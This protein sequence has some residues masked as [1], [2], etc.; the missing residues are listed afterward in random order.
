MWAALVEKA[1]A[2]MFGNYENLASGNIAEGLFYLTGYPGEN[3]SADEALVDDIVDDIYWAL[4]EHA[5]ITLAGSAGS[6]DTM[7]SANGIVMAHAYSILALQEIYD[8]NG[9]K[10][11]DLLTLRNPWGTEEYVGPWSDN[12]DLWTDNIK[13]QVDYVN[14]DDGYFHIDIDTF[15]GEFETYSIQY[16]EEGM[17]QSVFYVDELDYEFAY[18]FEFTLLE[19]VD[20]MAV[21]AMT[22][23]PRMY[24]HG[25]NSGD[26]SI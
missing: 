8:D 21:G 15:L 25:C 2:K 5:F 20:M 9:D 18:G 10:I 4:N 13:A 14:A 16:Y 26:S 22:I 24:A 7:T 12:S 23:S 19:D 6:S 3:F 11:T 1:A 17:S